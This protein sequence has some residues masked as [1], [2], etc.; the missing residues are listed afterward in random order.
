M[1]MLEMNTIEQSFELAGV[2]GCLF[3]RSGHP[4]FCKGLE[5]AVFVPSKYLTPSGFNYERYLK[6]GWADFNAR[7]CVSGLT[8]GHG[9]P[10]ISTQ[11][12]EDEASTWLA[13][14][15]KGLAES[16]GILPD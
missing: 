8:G 10:N 13:L 4:E 15:N 1:F 12:S 16:P 2:S 14:V 7:F 3:K 5:D 9:I 11:I 6:D